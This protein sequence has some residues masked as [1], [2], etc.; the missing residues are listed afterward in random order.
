MFDRHHL[1]LKN[2][3][4]TPAVNSPSKNFREKNEQET[5]KLL[6]TNKSFTIFLFNHQLI[7]CGADAPIISEMYL[8]TV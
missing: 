5:P 4:V 2:N 7:T 3:K 8:S 1:Q 6:F